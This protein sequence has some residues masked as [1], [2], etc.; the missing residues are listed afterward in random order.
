MLR[1]ALA[2]FALGVIGL[3]VIGRRKH[4]SLV[5]VT[6]TLTL[7]FGGLIVLDFT[8]WY[9]E[10]TYRM[11]IVRRLVPVYPDAEL[12]SREYF[13]PCCFSQGATAH[14]VYRFDDTKKGLET[15]TAF[16]SDLL[17]PL[18]WSGGVDRT[19]NRPPK[20]LPL[21]SYSKRALMLRPPSVVIVR[22][23]YQNK[24][25]IHVDVHF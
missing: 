21:A 16:Y 8:T 3:F 13:R 17:I 25:I 14:H 19:L 7:L 12:V 6:L 4:R 2:T 5:S 15:I 11:A 24:G 10:P 20:S 23:D 9:V 1:F 18:G 22:P